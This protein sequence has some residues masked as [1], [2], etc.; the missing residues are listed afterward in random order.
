M[1][2]VYLGYLASVSVSVSV[3]A[4][5]ELRPLFVAIRAV[6]TYGMKTPNQAIG[7]NGRSVGP[8]Q[9]SYAYWRDSGIRGTWDRCHGHAYSETVI[10]AYWKRHCSKALRQ[11]NFEVLAR[12][13]NGGPKGHTKRATWVYWQ[14]V[15]K[16]LAKNH[17]LGTAEAC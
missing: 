7:D 9:I 17:E 10:L 5:D 1:I 3:A 8:Y 14:K 16:N 4:G 15:R 11:R 2:A 6:E 13:H 12:I